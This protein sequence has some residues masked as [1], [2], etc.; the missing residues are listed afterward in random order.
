[1]HKGQFT[2]S[3]LPEVW[4]ILDE[5]SMVAF[6]LQYTLVKWDSQGPEKICPTK[7]MS[8]LTESPYKWDF[9]KKSENL[10]VIEIC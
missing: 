10:P 8:Q 5:I 1:M 9:D 4:K 2:S 6:Y 7:R 3:F